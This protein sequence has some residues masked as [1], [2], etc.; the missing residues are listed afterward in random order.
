MFVRNWKISSRLRAG[1][2]V[3]VVF[4]LLVVALATSGLLRARSMHTEYE[5]TLAVQRDGDRLM[6]LVNL[7][8]AKSQAIIRSAGMPEV[9]DRFTP[10]L[11][12][13][14]RRIEEVLSELSGPSQASLAAM[15]AQL[16]D[17]HRR[18]LKTRNEVLRHVEQGQTIEAAKLENSALNPAAKDLT[19]LAMALVDQ[20]G[21]ETAEAAKRFEDAMR[22][23]LGAMAGLTVAAVIASFWWARV[24]SRSIAEPVQEAQRV[25][26]AIAEGRLS[27]TVSDAGAMD[28]LGQMLSSMKRMQ[29]TLIQMTGRV[30]TQSDGVTST[31]LSMARDTR[32]LEDASRHHSEALN[33]SI[34][35]L[36]KMAQELMVARD[37]TLRASSLAAQATQS[38]ADGQASMRGVVETMREI[39]QSSQRVAEIIGVIDGISFQ[40][41]ILAL[42]AAVEAARAGEQ[43]RGFAVVAAEVRAL[44]QRSA[45]AAK[46]I[47]SLIGESVERVNKGTGLVD[48][49]GERIAGLR[50]TIAQ[51]AALM[52]VLKCTSERHSG[53][54]GSLKETMQRLGTS[55]QENMSLMQQ[56]S[57]AAEG[58]RLKAMELRD[59]V[60]CFEEA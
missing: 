60:S 19:Q 21:S 50:D 51:V 56:S 47:K 12:D 35:Q 5:A 6:T 24:I 40:T 13:S 3:L 2:G 37:E 16:K 38:A 59:A 4:L 23:A 27:L 41:N 1:F 52:D 39:Q 8:L 44:A 28:E 42:N 25:S 29:K 57:Q 34:H 36:L 26:S 58:L 20:V 33:E 48:E 18:Y 17:H 54:I 11:Q 7:D 43:G 31:S 49:T 22:W 53:D 45:T 55:N 10:E 46:E 14:A 30:R 9:S 32:T 15:T